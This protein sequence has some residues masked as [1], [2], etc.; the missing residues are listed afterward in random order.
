MRRLILSEDNFCLLI[1]SQAKAKITQM[2][3][4]LSLEENFLCV[5]TTI[6]KTEPDYFLE[7]E[8]VLNL[9][10]YNHLSEIRSCFGK[11]ITSKLLD[12][13]F[14]TKWKFN[15]PRVFKKF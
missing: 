15:E 6:L 3:L 9:I 8:G 10:N 4:T 12:I 5:F 1:K 14:D 7:S 2:A 11:L 13:F